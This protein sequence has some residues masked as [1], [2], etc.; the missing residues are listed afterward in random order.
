MKN[1]FFA[2]CHYLS[3]KGLVRASS[4]NL[5]LRTK[6]GVMQITPSGLWLGSGEPFSLV[7]VNFET[8]NFTGTPSTEWPLHAEIYKVRPDVEAVLHCQ[9]PYATSLACSPVDFDLNVIPEIPYYIKE[10]RRIP[11]SKPGSNLL[12]GNVAW[13]LREV[14]HVSVIQMQNHGQV[15]IG[16]SLEDVVKKATFFELACEIVCHIGPRIGSERYTTIDRESPC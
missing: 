14:T 10:Y 16:D 4:G 7:E 2:A 8:G 11:Y 6:P 9:S 5:S 15:V 3:E 12:A 1:S 13:V